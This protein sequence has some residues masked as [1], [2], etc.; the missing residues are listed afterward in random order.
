MILGSL[1]LLLAG[2]ACYYWF[3]SGLSL[4]EL[5]EKL[6]HWLVSLGLVNA[7]LIYIFLF[8]IRP[9]ILFPASILT[10]VA[11]AVF[12][13]WLGIL[14]TVIGENLSAA[15]AFFVA[16]YFGGTWEKNRDIGTLNRWQQSLR[17][18]ALVTVMTL[19]LMFL[20][21]D[22]VNY[23]AGMTAMRYRD[24]FIGTFIGVVP[25]MVSFVLFGSIL[26]A[27]HGKERGLVI[28]LSI[29]FFLAGLLI[30]VLMKRRERRLQTLSPEKSE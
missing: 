11:G 15:I 4:Q 28:G 8:M 25:G 3:N 26:T 2:L 14:F 30:A 23:A 18:N 12:G 7:A 27:N 1:W 22:L 21:F 19:R 6:E 17:D 29:F 16:R 10:L 20:H 24:F 9:L 5:P 13:P